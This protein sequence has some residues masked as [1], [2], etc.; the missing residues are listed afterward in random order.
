MPDG[1]G[2]ARIKLIE[3]LDEVSGDA[4]DACA[5]RDNPFLAYDFLHSLEVA[6][7]VTAQTGWLPQHVVVEDDEGGLLAAVPLYLKGHSRAS[8]CLTT[9]GPMP[10]NGP[11]ASIIRN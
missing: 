3:S 2:G 7:T 1:G 9:A 6:G 8:M 5:G 10:S 11:A 4:W